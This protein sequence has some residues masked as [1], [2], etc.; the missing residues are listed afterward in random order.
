MQHTL[1]IPLSELSP[2]DNETVLVSV[3]PE[4][5]AGKYVIGKH[6]EDGIDS[7]LVLPSGDDDVAFLEASATHFWRPLPPSAH[8]GEFCQFDSMAAAMQRIAELEALAK[9]TRSM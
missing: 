4:T 2:P 1:W 3:G 7:W 6:L 5:F 8:W 9:S